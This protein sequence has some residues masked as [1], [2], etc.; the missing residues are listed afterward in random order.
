[1]LG[2]RTGTTDRCAGSWVAGRLMPVVLVAMVSLPGALW[3]GARQHTITAE[4]YFTQAYV[5]EAELAP[6]GRAAVYGEMRWEPEKKKR[7]LDLWLVRTRDGQ[8][9]RLTFDVASDW[10]PRWSPDGRWIY[11]L[12]SRSKRVQVWRMRANGDRKLQVTREEKGVSAFQLS[13]DGRTLYYLVR[14]KHH[15]VDPFIGLRKRFG[16]LTYGHGVTRPSQL[17]A[18]DLTSWRRKRLIDHKRVIRLFAVSPD[19]RRAALVTTPNRHLITYEGWSRV[20]IVDLESQKTQIPDDGQWRKKA[21][22]PYGWIKSPRWSS[23]SRRLAFQISFDGY[24]TRIYVLTVG[25]GKIQRSQPLTRRAEEHI[26]GEM[27][28]RPKRA[29]LCYRAIDRAV[30]RV[31]CADFSGRRQQRPEIVSA[32]DGSVEGFSFSAD[33]E[34]LVAVIT[35]LTHPPD[36]FSM[37]ALPNQRAYRR[38]TRVN[39]QVDS[40]KLPI[41]RKVRWKSKDGTVVEGILELP[42]DYKK[43]QRLPLLVQLHGGP[44]SATRYVFQFWI[45]GR[46]LFAARGWAMLSPNYR[47]STGYG[48][49]F[50]TQLIGHKNDRD[51]DD[52][53]SGVDFLVKEGIADPQ[54]MAVMGWSNGGYLTNCVIARTTRFKAASSGAGVFDTA[55]QWMIEDTPGHVVNFNRGLPWR[56]QREMSKTSPLYLAHKIRTPTLIHVGERDQRVPLQH[57]RALYRALRHYLKVPV[58]LVVYPGEPHGLSQQ[59]HRRAKLLWDLKWFDYYVLGKRGKKP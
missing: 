10:H 39:R 28:W 48:D 53:L 42:P 25:Q 31:Y 19:G 43:G 2:R 17:W 13:A 40:W 27:R 51:V 21:P 41:I 11:F 20:E 49:R 36:L 54:R 8:T 22:S 4:D 30:D 37:A 16:K 15:A 9:T 38:L 44:T 7:N 59:T 50:M 58:E 57:S 24:P 45:Y 52:I 3:A 46:T 14:S 23:D 34:K 12:S 26:G 56:R 33:G 1:M 35:G 18:L 6:N 29:Q 32:G 47:G 5:V 55:M